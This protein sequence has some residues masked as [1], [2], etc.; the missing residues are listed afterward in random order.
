MGDLDFELEEC[1][2]ECFEPG[3]TNEGL[4]RGSRGMGISRPSGYLSI[5]AGGIE[6]EL[7][8]S[9][10]GDER[11]SSRSESSEGGTLGEAKTASVFA[12]TQFLTRSREFQYC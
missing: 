2:C 8:T 10:G 9:E 5:K 3:A 4:T 7:S 6:C 11:T 1:E 12:C